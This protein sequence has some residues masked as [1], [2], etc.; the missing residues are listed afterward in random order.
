METKDLPSKKKITS[1]RCIQLNFIKST[2]VK[3]D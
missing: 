2:R 3:A 1:I